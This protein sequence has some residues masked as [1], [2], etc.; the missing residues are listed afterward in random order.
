MKKIRFVAPGGS[1]YEVNAG[2]GQTLMQAAT[3]HNVPG[4]DADCG[5]SC[6]CATC[7]VFVPAATM[8]S[9]AAPDETELAMLECAIGYEPTQSRLSCQLLIDDLPD[10]IEI[11]V[12]LTQR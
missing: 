1:T 8:E 7:H 11:L 5:G 2:L 9:L 3:A 12:P 10:D 6:I 4:I